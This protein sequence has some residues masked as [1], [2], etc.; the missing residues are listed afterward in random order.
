MK[1]IIAV[2]ILILV[3]V[4]I[5]LEKKHTYKRLLVKIREQFGKKPEIRKCNFE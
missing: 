3:N 5:I 2:G 4:I 1:I